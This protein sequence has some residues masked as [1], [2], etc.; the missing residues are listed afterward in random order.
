[1][2]TIIKLNVEYA[3]LALTEIPVGYINKSVCGCGMTSVALENNINTILLV[4]N[5]E[6]AT[7]KAKQYPNE[8]TKN[9]L[10]PVRGDTTAEEIVKY[11]TNVPVIKIVCVYDSLHKVDYLLDRCRLI[12]D[13]SQELLHLS[14]NRDRAKAISY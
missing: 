1:M 8:R 11:I 9:K 12:I 4:P 10:L 13:E 2:E 5:I 3:T 14:S 6:L 7:N